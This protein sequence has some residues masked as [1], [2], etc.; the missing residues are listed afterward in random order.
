MAADGPE[1]ELIAPTL[2]QV[3]QRQ[4]SFLEDRL[5]KLMVINGIDTTALMGEIKARVLRR[6][7]LSCGHQVR[8]V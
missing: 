3:A 6:S 1:A 8:H 5:V 2:E 7:A 4:I